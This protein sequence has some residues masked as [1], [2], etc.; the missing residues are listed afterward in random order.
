MEFP[1][2]IQDSQKRR[3]DGVQPRPGGHEGCQSAASRNV[4]LSVNPPGRILKWTRAARW[5]DSKAEA[6]I[7]CFLTPEGAIGKTGKGGAGLVVVSHTGITELP[8]RRFVPNDAAE[9]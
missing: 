9:L 1:P 8:L 7:V 3:S 6:R 4:K 2:T 5:S